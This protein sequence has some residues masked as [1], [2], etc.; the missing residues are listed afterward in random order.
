MTDFHDPEVFRTVLGGLRTGVC[1][2][3][4]S[5][6]ILFWND[7]AE[8]IT[9]YLRHEVLGRHCKENILLHC[10]ENECS[11]CGNACPVRKPLMDGRQQESG[12][13]FHH[14]E[15]H[16]IP[17]HIWSF[18]IRDANGSVIGA[19]ESFEGR[20]AAEKKHAHDSLGAYG[21]L[22]ETTG[23]PNRGFTEFHLR[24]NLEKFAQYH[25]PFSV[26]LIRVN[27]AESLKH[28]HGREALDT[29]LGLVARTL[30]DS[31]RPVDFLGRWEEDQ[32]L[33]I[34]LN[35]GTAGAAKVRERVKRVL[36]HEGIQWWG[37]ELVVTT[38]LG[39]AVSEPGDTMESLLQRAARALQQDLA[40]AAAAGGGRE[41][42][43]GSEE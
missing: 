3:D 24:E 39:I 42:G 19:A 18:P 22:D 30:R 32:F 34:A 2:V 37:D 16:R 35:C 10:D 25:V 13:Y 40:K 23:V 29:V 12:M 36:D 7:G 43:G 9:G 28:T 38:S 33:T 15:G 14:K 4:R 41:N 27:D 1:L 17:V 21:C 5:R 20:N 26:L 11:L 8:R 31:F 6:K